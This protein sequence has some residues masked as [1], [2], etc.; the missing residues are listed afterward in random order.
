MNPILALIFIL[1][2]GICA[3]LLS[4]SETAVTAAS[5]LRLHQLAKKGKKNASSLLNL[6]NHMTA[7][8]SSI[9]LMNSCFLV[10]MPSIMTQLIGSYVG[11]IGMFF[12]SLAMGALVTIYIEVL[13]KIYVYRNPERI[14]MLFSPILQ[15]LRKLL[16]PLT[17]IIDKIAHQ[18]LNIFGIKIQQAHPNSNLDDLR[19]AIDLHIGEGAI[20]HERVML[21]SI[22][23]LSQVTVEEVMVHRKNIISF[24]IDLSTKL[25]CEKIFNTPYTRLPLWKGSPDNIIGVINIKD[26]AQALQKTSASQL[27]IKEI[28]TSAWFIP[29]T[30]VLF[31][32]LQ[33]FKE[34]QKHQA[35]VVDE[36]GSL[37]GMITLE[38]I[39]EEI[40][41]E[42]LDE[43]DVKL[44][45]VR[46]AKDGAYLVNGAVTLRDLNREYDW[47][48]PSEEASTLAG[49]ILHKTRSIPSI[50]CKLNICE[51]QMEILRR[52]QHQITLIRVIPPSTKHSII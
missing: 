47:D 36:Y 18:S 6:Q 35:F 27:Q 10:I 24:N 14:G 9:L 37:L 16:S 12:V 2:L 23:D 22:L 30:N 43:H 51:F 11:E 39:L 4:A 8:I 42:I 48:L 17:K 41:G 50:G 52:H 46:I 38:D 45:G 33:L 19:G 49:L 1:I 32:Q 5:R 40:V 20:A 31:T 28:M 13:P 34:K 7:V 3:A 15:M 29:D 21:K 25:L 26:L 44:L